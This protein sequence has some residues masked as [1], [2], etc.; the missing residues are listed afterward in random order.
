MK[1]RILTMSK[2]NRPKIKLCE[3]GCGQPVN[4]GRKGIP[5][6]FFAG[7]NSLTGKTKFISNPCACGCGEM[8][9]P[10][11]VFISGHNTSLRP[12]YSKRIKFPPQL[13]SCGCG[14][15]TNKNCRFISGH[16]FRSNKPKLESRLCEC[17][18]GELTSPGK[19]FINFHATKDGLNINS[20]SIAKMRDSIIEAFK[21][22]PT[23]ASRV[24]SKMKENWQDP[25]FALRMGIAQGVTPNKPE[26]KLMNI[27]NEL[28]PNE[29]KFTGDYSF[30]INGKNPDFTN[31]N[32]QKKLIEMYGDYWHKGDKPQ[33][34][35]DL[36]KPY[37]WD[38]LVIWEKELKD[39][40][41]VKIKIINF[42]EARHET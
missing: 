27:L 33:D 8:T 41:G 30:M 17:G 15:V 1:Q 20:E 12:G 40:E 38:T 10:G 3:C 19:R 32:G 26:M 6:R 37:G 21:N 5:Y 13:C 28:Y 23:Y 7:H 29:W 14:G 34:R 42:A 35:I 22:D 25:E 2:F 16:N 18:C 31:V 9:T 11:S 4:I 24:S 39:L 36:F